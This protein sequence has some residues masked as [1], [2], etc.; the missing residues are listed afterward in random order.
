MAEFHTPLAVFG[1]CALIA[2]SDFLLAGRKKGGRNVTDRRR[3][4]GILGIGIILA[5]GAYLLR[6][7]M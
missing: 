2:F 6:L 3:I 7:M 5:A 4:R 1:L